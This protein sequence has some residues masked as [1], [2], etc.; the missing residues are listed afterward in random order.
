MRHEKF[1]A[2]VFWF[3][4]FQAK[5]PKNLALQLNFLKITFC[6]LE[7]KEIQRLWNME[8]LNHNSTSSF[9]SWALSIFPI[10]GQ[11]V[12][13]VI[14]LFW[15]WLCL[16]DGAEL[17]P[18]GIWG[19]WLWDRLL[20]KLQCCLPRKCLAE[21]IETQDE[22][23]CTKLWISIIKMF[24]IWLF[25]QWPFKMNSAFLAH[26]LSVRKTAF[27]FEPTHDIFLPFFWFLCF[28]L[29]FKP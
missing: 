28:T 14:E 12:P 15:P 20:Y 9:F 25:F 13:Q 3:V 19:S 11:A 21:L 27:T 1:L 23:I 24:F 22:I 16:P 17:L 18:A 5:T 26:L 7:W 6:L 8:N 29:S 10:P 2:L 4:I